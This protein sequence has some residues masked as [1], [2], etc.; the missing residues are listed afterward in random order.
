MS[1]KNWID[2]KAVRRDTHFQ[3]VL[4]YYGIEYIGKTEQKTIFCPF[5][6]EKTPSCKVHFGKN[7]FNCFGC[8]AKGNVIDFIVKKEGGNPSDNQDFRKGAIKALEIMDN[9]PSDSPK[10]A[11]D[12]KK[13]QETNQTS[14]DTAS[15]VKTQN[16][17]SEANKVNKPL[18]FSL[19][20]NPDHPFLKKRDL[21]TTQ[22]AEFGL[23]FQN[24]GMMKNRIVFPIH[25]EDNNL[26]AYAGRWVDEKVPEGEMR[27][28]LPQHFYKSLV[29]YNLN[30]VIQEHPKTKHIV[31]VEGFW[32]TIRLHSAGIP[33]AA[34]MGTSI[35]EEQIALL[36]KFN[37]EKIT[38]IFDGDDAGRKAFE[39]T[40]P[41]LSEE[42]FVKSILLEEGIKP[43]TMDEQIVQSL[44]C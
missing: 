9:K 35:S 13:P 11:P 34:C 26:V 37:I 32:S 30:R 18:S 33:T 19:T 29:L 41:S 31:I 38:L 7:I 44:I 5:H 1:K 17:D 3:C 27:Y 2:F 43:D 39:N 40:L 21:D 20:P 28:K 4:D 10:T 6:Q 16:F 12:E 36:K 24:R 42:F 8:S 25:D 14:S 23:G 22:I 15:S